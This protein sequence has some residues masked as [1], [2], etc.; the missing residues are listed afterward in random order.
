V[1]PLVIDHLR[2]RRAVGILG[3]LLPSVLYAWAGPQDSISA[4][5]HSSARDIFVGWLTAIAALLL[6]YRGHDRGDR[7]CSLLGGLGLLVVAYCPTGRDLVG[8]IHL[9]GA[10]LFFGSVAV[11]AWR[12]GYGGTRVR[13]FRCLSILIVAGIV[14]A[15]CSELAGLSIYWAEW[16]SV[17]AFAGA[18]LC[19]GRVWEREARARP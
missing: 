16:V 8:L 13:T 2:L 10:L 14:G 18:W 9:G 12:F 15:V 7:I 19:K 3:A 11:L 1:N 17:L 5:W 4:Y 6:A